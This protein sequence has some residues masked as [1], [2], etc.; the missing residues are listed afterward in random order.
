MG[1]MQATDFK[2]TL[3]PA[4]TT[5]QVHSKSWY[6]SK[7]NIFNGVLFLVMTFSQ[8]MDLLT[9]ANILAPVV[10][11]FV[12]NPTEASHAIEVLTQAY[13]LINLYLRTFKTNSPVSV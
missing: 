8:V 6:S 5:V 11:V 9:G 1:A 2:V 12:K 3:M 4:G 13:T 7:M 10:G